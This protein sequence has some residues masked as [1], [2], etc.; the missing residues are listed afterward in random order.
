MGLPPPPLPPPLKSWGSNTPTKVN[1]NPTEDGFK[2]HLRGSLK[3]NYYCT[4]YFNGAGR[5]DF[6][7]GNIYYEGH[8]KGWALKIETFFRP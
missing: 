6:D 2:T 1:M 4:C 8:C 5:N 7:A 3:N